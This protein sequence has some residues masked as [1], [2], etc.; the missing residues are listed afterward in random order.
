M[1]GVCISLT[2]VKQWLRDDDLR[3]R[4]M[5]E[6]LSGRKKMCLA[7]SEAFAG[8]DVNGLRTTAQKTPDGQCYIVTGTKKW[9]TNGMFSDYFVTACRTDKGI[10]VLLIPRG[11]GVETKTIR[12]AYST[13]AGT[14]YVEFSNVRVPM[15]HLLGEEDQG[16][17]VIMSNFNH[18]RFVMV[19]STARWCIAVVEE[20]LKWCNQR[21][22]FKKK[23][24][25]Q[26]VLR[27]KYV[28]K[29]A[30]P[31]LGF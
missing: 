23:L 9:I 26:P 17:K 13:S 21:I 2:A 11:H 29:I 25:E 10:S 28:V 18:E 1:G 15:S 31:C 12:T 14:A 16:A 27:Q 4:V 6:V 30:R 20:C 24:I 3:E 22:S 19:C 7:I 8:S 5:E